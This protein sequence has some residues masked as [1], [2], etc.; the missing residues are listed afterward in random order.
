MVGKMISISP[1][2]WRASASCGEIHTSAI[3]SPASCAAIWPGRRRRDEEAGVVAAGRA[4]RGDP[5]G[6]VVDV[7]DRQAQALVAAQV[8]EA[9]VTRR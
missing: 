6:E 3:V 1:A 9:A 5:V 4:A 7:A 8:E 2:R